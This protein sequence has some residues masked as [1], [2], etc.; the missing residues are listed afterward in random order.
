MSNAAK[1][2]LA[3]LVKAKPITLEEVK[4]VQSR[5][6]KA[7]DGKVPKGGLVARLQRA[8]QRNADRAN[9]N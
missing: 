4:K 9:G 5:F 8:A 2:K 1:P 6:A 7:H 3:G